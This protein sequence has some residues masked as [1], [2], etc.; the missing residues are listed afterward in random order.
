MSS[1]YFVYH[2]FDL[3][4]NHVEIMCWTLKIRKQPRRQ[5]QVENQAQDSQ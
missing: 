5:S 2:K 1:M 3:V 4:N